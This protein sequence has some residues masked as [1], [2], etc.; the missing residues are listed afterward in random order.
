MTLLNTSFRTNY[1]HTYF[2]ATVVIPDTDESDYKVVWLLHGYTADD[3]TWIRNY[4][5]ESLAN[6]YNWAIIMPEGRNSFYTDSDFIPY[7]SFFT[8]ELVPKMQKLL[9]ISSKPEDNYIAGVSMGGYGALKIGLENP[10][11]FS[12]IAAMSPVADIEHF[13]NNPGSPM[14]LNAFDTIFDSTE[15]IHDNQLANI[16]DNTNSTDQK[17]LQLCGDDDFMHDDNIELKNQLT[18]KFKDNYKWMPVN[19]DHSWTTWV[20]NVDGVFNWLNR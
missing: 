1:L 15:K 20:E 9:P 11:K 5:V 18:K 19:G 7:Y 13:R 16:L 12:R 2:K 14:P 4:N 3:T 8:K 10:D 17:I 6:K